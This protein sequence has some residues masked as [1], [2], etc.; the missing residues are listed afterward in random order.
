MNE[1]NSRVTIAVKAVKKCDS[2]VKIV[3]MYENKRPYHQQ[4]YERI[5]FTF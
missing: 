3:I 2:F 5:D 1:S 4:M